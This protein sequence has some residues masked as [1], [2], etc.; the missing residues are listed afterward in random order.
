M[1]G[2]NMNSKRTSIMPTVSKQTGTKDLFLKTKRALVESLS[3]QMFVHPFWATYSIARIKLW[4]S[5]VKTKEIPKLQVKAPRK[6]P[7][8]S[9]NKPPHAPWFP[10]TESLELTFNQGAEGAFQPTET[11]SLIWWLC[12]VTNNE[13]SSGASEP[14]HLP[15]DRLPLIPTKECTRTLA[16]WM[17][18]LFE[19]NRRVF[20]AN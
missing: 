16:A 8:W 5:T 14:I 6:L 18:A 10:M 4:T 15:V 17:V 11:T 7:K 2:N 1:R 19:E 9:R 3:N 12:W 13:S 20:L